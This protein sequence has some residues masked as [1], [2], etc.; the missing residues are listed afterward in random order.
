MKLPTPSTIMHGVGVFTCCLTAMDS[1]PRVNDEE[2]TLDIA[3]SRRF[4][5]CGNDSLAYRLTD[6]LLNRHKGQVTVIL[7]SRERAYGPRIARLAG[8]QLVETPRPDAD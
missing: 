1:V 6:E 8:V 2:I 3:E 5:V 7:T 4:V